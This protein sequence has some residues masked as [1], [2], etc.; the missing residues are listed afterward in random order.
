MRTKAILI[1]SVGSSHLEVLNKTTNKLEQ[2]IAEKYPDYKVCQ[3]FSGGFILKKMK[4]L[5]ADTFFCVEEML[6]M[7]AAEGI[8]EVIVQPTYIISG[9][10]ND[11]L[12]EIVQNYKDK[13]KKIVKGKPLFHVKE[14]YQKTLEAILEAAALEEEEALMLIGHGTNHHANTEYQNLEYTAYIQGSRNVFVSTL[15][16][17]KKTAI[18][19]RKLQITGCT[20]V[21][22]M[23]LLFVAGKHAKN[24]IAGEENSWKSRLTEA[25]Y[26]V[27]PMLVGLGELE[28]IQDLFIEHLEE[29]ME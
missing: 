11:R 14:D 6:E 12:R 17:H 25:G 22:L 19:M 4:E 16:G 3:A 15:E 24:D 18:L 5:K 28:K 9:R 7:L 21:R 8:E 10:E 26:A 1:V 13:F 2:K 20:K 23:P 27:A 29:V